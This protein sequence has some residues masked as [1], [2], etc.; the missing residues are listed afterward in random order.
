M[1][2]KHVNGPVF[3]RY[4]L[5]PPVINSELAEKFGIEAPSVVKLDEGS[6]VKL[7]IVLEDKGLRMT[8]HATIDWVK[9]DEST[10]EYRVGLSRLSLTD[11]EFR[12]LAEN[13]VARPDRTLEL[14]DTVRDKGLESTPVTTA[15]TEEEIERV[16]AVT[17]PVSLIEAVDA[18]RGSVPFSKFVQKALQEA[19][20]H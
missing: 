18:K 14:G 10:K 5:T 8:C 7:R 13:F 3:C 11:P 16:K 20:S 9:Q 12:I 6:N 2:Y 19:V 17:L 4:A 1:E 15:D